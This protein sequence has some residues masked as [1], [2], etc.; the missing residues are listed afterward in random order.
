VQEIMKKTIFFPGKMRVSFR[1]GPSGHLR[2]DPS[3]EDDENTNKSFP[4][5]QVY[6]H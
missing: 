5:G 1:K 6:S 2:Q 4:S 3:E